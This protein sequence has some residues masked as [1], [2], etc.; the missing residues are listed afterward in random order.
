VPVI[1]QLIGYQHDDRHSHPHAHRQAKNI[2]EREKFI[3]GKVANGN[4][5]V[6]PDHNCER[7]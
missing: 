2:D 4:Q 6:I 3:P 7:F 1:C 5:K